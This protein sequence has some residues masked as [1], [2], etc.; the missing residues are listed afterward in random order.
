MWPWNG[1]SGNA[2][3]SNDT[4]DDWPEFEFAFPA[5]AGRPMGP[6]DRPTPARLIDYQGTIGLG[7]AIGACY[8]DLGFKGKL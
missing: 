4:M 6:S 2:G 1:K 5:A 8:D 7:V 3:T